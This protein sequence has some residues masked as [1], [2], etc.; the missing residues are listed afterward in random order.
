MFYSIIGFILQTKC[1]CCS[2]W[3]CNTSPFI[4]LFLK[5]FLNK[6]HSYYS[7]RV[8]IMHY[9]HCFTNLLMEFVTIYAILNLQN[10]YL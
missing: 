8:S 2:G 1:C 7:L 9:R 4:L 3:K 10:L 5:I 6:E